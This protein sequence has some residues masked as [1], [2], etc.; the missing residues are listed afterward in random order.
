[1]RRG[2]FPKWGIQT[3][4]RS[5]RKNAFGRSLYNRRLACELLE[6]RRLLSISVGNL[7]WNDLNSNG[8]HDIGERG[9]AGVAVELFQSTDSIVGNGDD[10]PVA[11][12]TTD[13]AGNYLLDGLVQGENYYLVFRTPAGYAFTTQD[14]G[15]D[16]NLDSDTNSAGVTELFALASDTSRTDLDAGLT[17]AVPGFGFA[18]GFGS[19]AHYEEPG[20][21]WLWTTWETSM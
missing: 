10:L 1:M 20:E 3:E 17:G 19:S 16:D 9:V 8:I 11:L 4:H 5:N 12:T 21:P 15:G 13:A 18:L 6:D 14:A 7:V 2:L